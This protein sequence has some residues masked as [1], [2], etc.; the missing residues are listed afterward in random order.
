MLIL[1]LLFFGNKYSYWHLQLFFF[2]NFHRQRM[3]L[4]SPLPLDNEKNNNNDKS[5][6]ILG[7]DAIER[8]EIVRDF[9]AKLGIQFKIKI[10]NERKC[11][12]YFKIASNLLQIKK[13]HAP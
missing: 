4:F 1:L 9:P 7:F 5:Y 2:S 11:F 13:K 8:G 12:E 3:S 6:I 10:A